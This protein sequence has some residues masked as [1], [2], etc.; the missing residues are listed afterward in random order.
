MLGVSIE[1]GLNGSNIAVVMM[2]ILSGAD[3]ILFVF[4][5]WEIRR[6]SPSVPIDPSSHVKS[7]SGRYV[8]QSK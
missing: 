1:E 8:T 6:K 5:V 4:V 7:A 3:E 2:G